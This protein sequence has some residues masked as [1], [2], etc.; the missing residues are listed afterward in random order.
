MGAFLKSDESAVEPNADLVIP[1][2][3]AVKVRRNSVTLIIRLIVP[4]L[5]VVGWTRLAGSDM[6]PENTMPTPVEVFRQ[7]TL[8][9]QNDSLLSQIGM[10]LR[11]SLLGL[12]I[13]ASLGFVLGLFS[14]LTTLGEELIDAPLQMFRAIPFIALTPL[15]ILWFG[16]GESPKII[17]ISLATYYPM[18]ANTSTGVRNVDKKIVECASVFGLSRKQTVRKVVIPLALP[19]IFT[20]LRLSM[21]ISILALV[22]AEQINAQSGI[23]N[24]LLRSANYGQNFAVFAC[25]IIYALAGLFADLLIRVVERY[26]LRWRAG[27]SVR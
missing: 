11:R 25:V 13:G 17:L 19:N 5:I 14:G 24:L 4:V 27:V 23:G 12:L 1:Q 16:I 2:V 21:V 10:S 26:T 20:G 8:L 3:Q 22:A 18:Y 15:F 6:L 7:W 9:W